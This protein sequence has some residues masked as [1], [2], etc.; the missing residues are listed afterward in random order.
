LIFLNKRFWKETVDPFGELKI[1][2]GTQLRMS[3]EF[4][5]RGDCLWRALR[6]IALHVLAPFVISLTEN[7]INS[8]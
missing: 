5:K 1:K 3:I 7:I 6:A 2:N 8:I 4:E